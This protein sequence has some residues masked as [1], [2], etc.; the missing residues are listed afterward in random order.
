MI[1]KQLFNLVK[2]ALWQTAADGSLFGEQTDWQAIYKL[3]RKQTVMGI[4]YD[5]MLTLPADLQP[6]R[7]LKLQWSN[8]LMQREDN[9]HLL[10]QRIETLFRHY[11]AAGLKPLLLKG[12]GVAQSYPHPEHRQPGDI[13]VCIGEQDYERAN[14][15]L[16]ELGGEIESESVK[17]SHGHWQGVTV[18]NHYLLTQFASPSAQSS[19]WTHQWQMVHFYTN[20]E[21]LSRILHLGTYRSL[22]ASAKVDKDFRYDSP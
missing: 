14:R 17:H 7:A 9:N 20:R 5:G 18:E 6:Q 2:A 21:A 11:Q 8:A 22:L 13:D 1:A 15:L 19:Q 4:A 16:A 10:N 3:A 12:Q